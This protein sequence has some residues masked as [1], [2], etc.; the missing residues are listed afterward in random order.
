MGQVRGAGGAF[1][2]PAGP[3]PA[4]DGGP[5]P[6][7]LSFPDLLRRYLARVLDEPVR[8]APENLSIRLHRNRAVRLA[9]TQTRAR[10]VTLD[11]RTSLLLD[12][13][14]LAQGHTDMPL[15]AGTEMSGLREYGFG[16]LPPGNPAE[17]DLASP[18][19]GE[20]AALRGLGLN[21][22]DLPALLTVGRE[23]EFHREGSEGGALRCWP[24]GEE[25]GIFAGSRRSVPYDELWD[26]DRVA[27]P[28]G[29]RVFTGPAAYQSRL[30]DCPHEDLAGDGDGNVAGPL[31]AALGDLR[32]L[33]DE[34]RPTRGHAG[35]TGESYRDGLRSWYTPLDVFV[36][37]GPPH[38]RI[39]ELIALIAAGVVEMGGPGPHIAAAPDGSVVSRVKS[40]APSG[41]CPRSSRPGCPT[42]TSGAPPTRSCG[43]C[44]S[45][46]PAPLPH[47]HRHGRARGDRRP[48]RHPASQPLGGRG[49]AA[50][51]L[52]L[53]VRG[54]ERDGALG[55]GGGYPG[56]SRLRDLRKTPTPSRASASPSA[57]SGAARPPPCPRRLLVTHPRHTQKER[58]PMPVHS[59]MRGTETGTDSGLPN[60]V[61]ATGQAAAAL[62]EQA[63]TAA[64]PETEDERAPG[65]WHTEWQ[66][67]REAPR[68]TAGAARTAAEPTEGLEVLPAPMRRNLELTEGPVVS[69]R[70]NAVPAPPLDT[71]G[72]KRVL[73]ARARRAATGEVTFA[74]ALA[75]HPQIQSRLPAGAEQ[76]P[77][78]EE[79]LGA[80]DE[81]DSRV[82]ARL[83]RMESA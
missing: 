41:E 57:W 47:P 23:G 46:G 43:T 38:G 39:E 61:R 64:M 78:P 49:G 63:W 42:S 45:A 55:H 74:Q 79:Y 68:L 5:W 80:A 33:R 9:E 19:P 44:A 1:W 56:R 16:S 25:P 58:Y 81:L 27:H 66:P 7:R 50:A 24:S 12:C 2:L 37:T 83:A 10:A 35:I 36:S 53:R 71:A 14:V 13:V 76:L 69:E 54:A 18:G 8:T 70:P 6:T 75:D 15:S 72:T 59:P 48:G 51:P 26:W 34:V 62:S 65:A 21:F 60:P 31:K 73:A 4:G 32:D 11:E 28:Y 30:L 3:G 52:P 40:P 17:A 20:R 22:S 82:L 77:A 29:D 67:P